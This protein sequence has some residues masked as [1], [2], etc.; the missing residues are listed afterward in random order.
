MSKA[1]TVGGLDHLIDNEHERENLW[2]GHL[3][4][5]VCE[6]SFIETISDYPWERFLEE[7]D[8]K[9]KVYLFAKT[10]KN[11]FLT[12]MPHETILCNDRDPSWISNKI[13][14]L[15]NEKNTSYQSYIQDGKN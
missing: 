6:Y 5:N 3:A 12:F 8:V 14:N 13:E 1:S 4:L 7:K 2:A 10:I 11:I 9:K 15:S